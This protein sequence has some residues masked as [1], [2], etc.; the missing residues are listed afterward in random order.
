MSNDEQWLTIQEAAESLGVSLRQCYRFVE[1]G[2]LPTTKYG[3]R[4]MVNVR[5]IDNLATELGISRREPRGKDERR[6]QVVQQSESEIA[7]VVRQL[8]EELRIAY[9]TIGELRGELKQRLLPD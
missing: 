5:D 1:A 6:V 8:Q 4:Q 2:K 7:Q 9:L 3:R